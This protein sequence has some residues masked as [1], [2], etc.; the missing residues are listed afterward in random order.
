MHAPTARKTRALFLFTSGRRARL[1]G[2]DPFPRDLF[3]GYCQLSNRDLAVDFLEEKDLE[4]AGSGRPPSRLLRLAFHAL[5][6][7]LPASLPYAAVLARAENLRRLNDADV[8]VATSH[9]LGLCSGLLKR[10]GLLRS[11]VL[12]IAMGALPFRLSR[13]SRRLTTWLLGACDLAPISDNE[14]AYLSQRLGPRQSIRYLPFG[15]DTEF[16]T[17]GDDGGDYVLSIGNDRHRDYGTLIDAW[18]PRY[19]KLRI[20][21]RLPVTTDKGNIE[22]IAGDWRERILSDT[23]IR[24]LTQNALFVVVPI[25][26]TIQ[27]SGQSVCLQAMSCARTVIV[28]AIEGLK[29]HEAM[30]DGHTCKLVEP[31]SVEGLRRAVESVLEDPATSHRIGAAARA[32]VKSRL[33]ASVTARAMEERLGSSIVASAACAAGD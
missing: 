32:M 18:Q 5:F 9:T 19:P 26:E 1:A 17:P 8:V 28:S 24:E 10:M 27:P 4:A 16:W 31:G 20:V 11:R 12:F 30:R 25:R 7:D 29:D 13:R 3:Y 22:V 15:I 23:E 6:R 14:A 2:P 33:G 21:T